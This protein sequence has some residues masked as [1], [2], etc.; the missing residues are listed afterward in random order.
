MPKIKFINEKKE[1]EVESGANLRQAA[2]EN[3]IQVH[4]HMV[5]LPE[6]LVKIANCHGMGTCGTCHVH[7]KKG[8]E[9]CSPKGAFEK[10]RLGV[11][12]FSIGHED[13]IRL[14]CQTKV[15]GDIEVE[16]RPKLNLSGEHFWE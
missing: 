7:I 6:S 3:G 4:Q 1:I 9:N 12:T 13:E 16:T 8:M 11:A 10:F 2:L 5:N 15:L 14:A